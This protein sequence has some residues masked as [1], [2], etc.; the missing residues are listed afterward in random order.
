MEALL[1]IGI[2]LRREVDVEAF[3]CKCKTLG[4]AKH[5]IDVKVGMLGHT[6]ILGTR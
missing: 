4:P 5:A 3:L 1:D 6:W 2:K